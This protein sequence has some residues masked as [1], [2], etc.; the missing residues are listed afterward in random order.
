MCLRLEVPRAANP[1]LPDRLRRQRAWRWPPG[2]APALAFGATPARPAGP[3]RSAGPGGW[4]TVATVPAGSSTLLTAITADRPGDAWAV[5]QVFAAGAPAPLVEHWN[6]A[7]WRR[8]ALP[9]GLVKPGVPYDP[10]TAAAGPRDLWV[11]GIAGQWQHW[12]GTW[13][14]GTLSDAIDLDASAMFGPK[15]VW[16]FGV[17]DPNTRPRPYAAR[18]D[19]S[20]WTR[21]AVPGHDGIDAVSA[22]SAR[23]IWAV[24]GT[25]QNGAWTGPG[26][27]VHWNGRRWQAVGLPARLATPRLGSVLARSATD[28]WAGGATRNRDGGSTEAVGHWNGRRWTVVTLPA[29]AARTHY[30]LTQ[31]AA[32]GAGGIWAIGQCANC[33]RTPSRLWHERGG[34][35]SGP[36][37]PRL[38]RPRWI[39]FGLAAAGRSIWADGAVDGKRISGLIARRQGAQ[40]SGS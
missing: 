26:A 13:T 34:R 23:D 19:G 7:A 5:G 22:V 30:H 38:A 31:L 11:F 6:G 24:L 33:Q 39:L 4:R 25:P 14:A 29:A 36:F 17:H 28:V 37:V 8:V 3:A 1:D 18:Y 9:R 12:D 35:W 20:R 40:A 15:D 10:A 16:A 32:D 2:L 21:I 27:L